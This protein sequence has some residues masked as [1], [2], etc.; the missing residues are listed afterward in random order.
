M[1]KDLVMDYTQWEKGKDYP[2]FFDD[3]ETL[4]VELASV[5]ALAVLGGAVVWGLH[6]WGDARG[7]KASA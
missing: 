1:D 4:G 6:R 5:V 2:E 7:M 3:L